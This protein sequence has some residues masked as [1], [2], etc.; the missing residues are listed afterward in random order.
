MPTQVGACARV[1]KKFSPPINL[2][3]HQGLGVWVDGDGKG[4]VINVQMRGPTHVSRAYGEH[5]IVVD[6]TG[7]RYFELI[8]PDTQSDLAWPYIDALQKMSVN[9]SAIESLT[10]WYNNIP[11][12][13]DAKCE[14]RAIKAIPL[15]KSKIVNPTLKINGKAISFLTEIETG[16]YLEFRSMSDCKLYGPQGQLLHDVR[17]AGEIP[18]MQEGENHVEFICKTPAGANSRANVTVITQGESLQD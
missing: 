4:E 9:Y 16:S 8:E 5:Y 18:A 14:L 11:S 12:G 7:W 15:V 10:L 13:K 2:G 1:E 3:K 17:I 6:F